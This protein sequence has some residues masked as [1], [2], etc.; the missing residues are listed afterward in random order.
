MLLSPVDWQVARGWYEEGIPAALV[1][2]VLQDLFARRAERGQSRRVSSLRYC[3]RAVEDAWRQARE[4]SGGLSEAAQ[5]RTPEP[6]DWRETL[7][8]LVERLPGD[9]PDDLPQ[10]SQLRQ[11]ILE[12]GQEDLAETVEKRLAEL[13]RALLDALF[14]RMTRTDRDRLEEQVEIVVSPLVGKV[15]QDELDQTRQRRLRQLVREQ[16][17]LPVLSLFASEA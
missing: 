7:T 9:L 3:S 10:A 17:H 5:R 15:P 6:R 16:A 2:S 4:L 14:S 11:S 13:E 8:G 1:I 12:L